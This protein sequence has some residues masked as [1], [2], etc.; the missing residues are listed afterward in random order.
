MFYLS[1]V[2]EH[3]FA[4]GPFSNRTK[5]TRERDMAIGAWWVR[6]FGRFLKTKGHNATRATTG[7]ILDTTSYSGYNTL[8][9]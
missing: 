2:H 7:W 1:E 5:T 6:G 4:L 3:P 8:S 9:S